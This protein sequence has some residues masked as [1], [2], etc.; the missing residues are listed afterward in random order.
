MGIHM[1]MND[2]DMKAFMNE[3]KPEN[4]EYKAMAYGTLMSGIFLKLTIGALSN[5][6]CY[7]GITDNYFVLVE[8]GAANNLVNNK[9]IIAFDDIKSLNISNKLNGYN[10][11]IESSE[12]KLNILLN[13][14]K[15]I[16]R[17]KN[18]K[19]DAKII[20]ETLKKYEK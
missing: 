5:S 6:Y 1:F 14:K 15:G 8:T 20:V 18:Q 3:V 9:F 11:K 7:L 2:E 10:I 12:F 19:E 4:E 13:K 16:Q 17:V